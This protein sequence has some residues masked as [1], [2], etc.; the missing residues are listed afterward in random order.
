MSSINKA[1]G[2]GFRT[3]DDRMCRT[4][5]AFELYSSKAP[6]RLHLLQQKLHRHHGQG[7]PFE[8][9]IQINPIFLQRSTSSS[10]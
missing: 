10:F 4:V 9:F 6:H 8:D 7:L 3:H 1:N 2:S 5:R